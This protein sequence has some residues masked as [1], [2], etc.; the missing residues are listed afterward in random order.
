MDSTYLPY[1]MDGRNSES[2]PPHHVLF[3]LKKK[4]DGDSGLEASF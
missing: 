1:P 4:H 2:V 3:M